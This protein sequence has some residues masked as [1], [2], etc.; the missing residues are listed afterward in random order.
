MTSAECR[1]GFRAVP[2]GRAGSSVLILLAGLVLMLFVLA[3]SLFY[4]AWDV[5][6]TIKV[7]A[8]RQPLRGTTP[9]TA[10]NGYARRPRQL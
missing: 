3:G 4:L 2:L 6:Q 9:W 10:Y 7:R 5:M 8:T 1:A